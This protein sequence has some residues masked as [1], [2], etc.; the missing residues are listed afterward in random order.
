MNIDN[1][2]LPPGNLELPILIVVCACNIWLFFSFSA[3]MKQVAAAKGSPS[4]SGKRCSHTFLV[5]SYSK[6]I[7]GFFVHII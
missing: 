4:V 3:P 1:S 6:Q 2:T 5:C 7:A